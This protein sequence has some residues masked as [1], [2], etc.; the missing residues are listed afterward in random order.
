MKALASLVLPLEL[1]IRQISCKVCLPDTVAWDR[2]ANITPCSLDDVRVSYGVRIHNIYGMV[3][4][5]L[6]ERGFVGH[7]T[8]CFPANRH[9]YCIRQDPLLQ[10]TKKGCSVPFLHGD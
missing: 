10:N 4:R 3:D 5:E 8:V 2:R 6:V 1:V 7:T 9:D